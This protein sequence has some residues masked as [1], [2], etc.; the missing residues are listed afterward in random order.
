MS[1]I[2][3]WATWWNFPAIDPVFDLVA[4]IH[5][6]DPL[7]VA[8]QLQHLLATRPLVQPIDIL[9]FQNVTQ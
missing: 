7:D 3:F 9:S 5:A 6:P 4:F 8:V 2:A 1:I